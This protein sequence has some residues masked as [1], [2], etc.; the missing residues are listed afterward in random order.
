[1]VIIPSAVHVETVLIMLNINN[2]CIISMRHIRN[3]K[4]VCQIDPW[5]Y[6]AILSGRRRRACG[7]RQRFETESSLHFFRIF[8]FSMTF[9]VVIKGRN[10]RQI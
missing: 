5:E 3:Y 10:V 1:M 8:L 7:Y 4:T 9:V 2:I 6:S